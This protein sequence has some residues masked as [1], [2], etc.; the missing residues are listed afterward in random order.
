MDSASRLKILESVSACVEDPVSVSLQI[1]TSDSS[2]NCFQGETAEVRPFFVG[3]Q[4]FPLSSTDISSL[5]YDACKETYEKRLDSFINYLLAHNDFYEGRPVKGGDYADTQA[6]AFLKKIYTE[7]LPQRSIFNNLDDL[8][9][10][11]HE[12]GFTH[13]SQSLTM[14]AP[15]RDNTFYCTNDNVLSS[16]SCWQGLLVMP[17]ST[18]CLGRYVL[19]D[20]TLFLK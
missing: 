3:L 6:F 2:Y 11:F 15:Q 4:K 10:S 13:F 5:S 16:T 19:W 17:Y 7:H 18:V 1:R 8:R 14:A 12:G 20:N 9:N